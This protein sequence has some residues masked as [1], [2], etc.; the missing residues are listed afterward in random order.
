MSSFEEI[1]NE[2]I[3]KLNILKEKG[4]N[5]YPVSTN[6]DFSISEVFE[7]FS[8]LSK[9]KKFFCVITNHKSSIV[10]GIRIYRRNAWK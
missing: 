6:R 2:R 1:R 4:I 7:D 5:P 3:K 8:K 10:L 9:R